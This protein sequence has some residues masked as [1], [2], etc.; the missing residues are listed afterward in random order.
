MDRW[1][2]LATL[3][4][5]LV[6]ATTELIGEGH[7]SIG[8][9]VLRVTDRIP[10]IAAPVREA[11][12]VRGAATDA[13]L[14]VVRAVNRLVERIAGVAW[15]RAGGG[16]A[17]PDLPLRA[18]AAGSPAWTADALVG[19]LNGFAGDHLHATGNALD[20][21]MRLRIEHA[22]PLTARIAVLVHGLSATEWSWA[23]EAVGGDPDAHFGTMLARDAGVVPV[24]ARYNTGRPVAVNGRLL[25]GALEEL[26]R[27]WPVPVEA[28]AIIGH[29]MGGL[30]GRS[31]C[32]QGGDST[33]LPRVRQVVTLGTPHQGAPLARLAEVVE[34]ALSAV[35]LPATRIGAKILAGRSAGI[36]DLER[37][38]PEEAGVPA[39]EGIRYTF[40]GGT[41]TADPDHVAARVLGDGMVSRASAAGP[42]AGFPRE[43]GRIGGVAHY[44]IQCDPGVYA[45]L[46]EAVS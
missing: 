37:G 25:A 3:V 28:I 10:A 17:V 46:L 34:Q 11:D 4:H 42:G 41:L 33:W 6:D 30:V 2:G 21:G 24:Y 36:R 44:R 32:A 7:A 1:R 18:D 5:D 22:V 45:R 12:E 35:D 8:R 19:A 20:L 31:A 23:L 27:T 9:N 13:T 43:V 38:L 40:L 15:D 39:I 14:G 26:V 29:S 16:P